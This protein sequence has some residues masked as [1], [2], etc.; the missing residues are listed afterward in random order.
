MLVALEH[1]AA[2]LLRMTGTP[3]KLSGT[4]GSVRTPPPMLGQHTAAVLQDDLGLSAA[5]VDSLRARG[6]I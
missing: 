2:G 4:P 3:L 1:E 6:V 5:Q